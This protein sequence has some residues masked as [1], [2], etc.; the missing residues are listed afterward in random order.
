MSTAAS[1]KLWAHPASTTKQIK[2]VTLE[3]AR[4]WLEQHSGPLPIQHATAQQLQPLVHEDCP[5]D[6]LLIVIAQD[7]VTSARLLTEVNSRRRRDPVES[8]ESAAS[9]LGQPSLIGLL[10][11]LLEQKPPALQPDQDF[12]QAQL[13]DRAHHN[14]WQ[15]ST[16]AEELGYGDLESLRVCARL[17]YLGELHCCCLTPRDYLD[18]WRRGG[19]DK[20]AIEV[21]GFDFSELGQLIA[22]RE[23]LP[24]RVALAQPHRQSPDPKTRLLRLTTRLCRHC[25]QGWADERVTTDLQQLA[26]LIQRPIDAVARQVHL[27]AVTAARHHQTPLAWPPASRLPLISDRPWS[28]SATTANTTESVQRADT[29][30]T[31][32]PATAPIRGA[33]TRDRLQYLLKR[34]D[35]TQAQLLQACLQGLKEELGFSRISLFLLSRDR[36]MLLNRLSLGLDE[37]APLRRY[38]VDTARA[39]LLRRLLEKR[40]AVQVTPQNWPRY[41]KLI[42]PSLLARL[43][44]RDFVAMSVFIADKPIGVVLADRKGAGSI[45]EEDFRLFKQIVN[46]C[47]QALTLATGRKN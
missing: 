45:C 5:T 17:M 39:G 43:D 1:C 19:D 31:E 15:V 14:A 26:E 4:R 10:R 29:S 38:G 35:S 16:F 41:E 24:E 12:L 3:A 25:E 27:C 37:Q 33:A 8:L 13:I 47:T 11:R 40:L 20:T 32:P 18:F 6:R 34:K 22:E 28:P 42:P 7:P 9:L 2:P 44:T 36:K 30:P 46:L 21:F 23:R